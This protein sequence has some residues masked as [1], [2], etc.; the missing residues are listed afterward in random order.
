MKI[1]EIDEEVYSY[2]QSKAIPYEDKNPNDTIRRLLELNKAGLPSP[3][4]SLQAR[5]PLKLD[6]RK[7]PPAKL[8]ELITAG[9]L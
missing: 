2:L 9:Y 6:G 7:T 4:K 1:V 8:Q 3:V 5:G